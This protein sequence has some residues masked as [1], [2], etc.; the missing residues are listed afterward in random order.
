MPPL[1]S[2]SPRASA[3]AMTTVTQCR[4]TAFTTTLNMV[5]DSGSL[6]VALSPPERPSRSTRPPVPPWLGAYNRY[7]AVSWLGARRRIP[8]GLLG[9][10][11][12]PRLHT[13]C[14]GPGRSRT[15]P[16][17][18]RPQA[19]EAAWLKG[20][21]TCPATCPE[22]MEEGVVGDR[23]SFSLFNSGHRDQI[24]CS[25]LGGFSKPRIAATQSLD[26]G[27]CSMLS[28]LPSCPFIHTRPAPFR[29]T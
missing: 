1:L 18:S 9:T 21:G 11:T 23:G 5:G 25:L 22:P 16:P 29:P 27:L 28:K 6:C 14:A 8:P 20:G 7:V 4:T 2:H 13:P 12:C 19:S 10:W 15:G 26:S 24:A 3:S 17:P